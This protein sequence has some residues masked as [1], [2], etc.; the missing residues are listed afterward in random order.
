MVEADEGEMLT[1]DNQHPPRSNEHLD[2]PFTF[3]EPSLNTA[4]SELRVLE[5]VVQE[6]FEGSPPSNTH[7]SKGK[8]KKRVSK[9]RGDLFAWLILF[10]PKLKQE[11]EVIT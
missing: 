7:I 9:F 5:E 10:Q 6:K 8:E 3:G 4:N 11:R 2:L 1:L